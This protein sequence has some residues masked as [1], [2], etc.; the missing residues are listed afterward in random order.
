MPGGRPR[1]IRNGPKKPL[2]AYT[3]FVVEVRNNVSKENPD[4]QFKEVASRVGQM[5]RDLKD[6]HREKYQA[7]AEQDKMRYEREKDEWK[8]RAQQAPPE[9]EKQKRKKR[10]GAPKNPLSA[11]TYY[12]MDVRKDVALNN[13][14]MSFRDVAVHVGQMWRNLD[15]ES[16]SMYSH[17]AELDKARY[18]NEMIDWNARLQAEATEAALESKNKK[19]KKSGPKNPLSAYTYFVME[20]RPMV[21]VENPKMTF[22]EVATRVGQMWRG[23]SPESRTKYD[24]MAQQDKERYDREKESMKQRMAQ[25]S[26]HSQH[27]LG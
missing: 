11:Y 8:V 25:F 7:L 12:I 22:G 5:W 15:A 4:L 24:H 9:D 6:E 27:F 14:H 19:K 20:T 3:L 18:E 2:S 26:H 16:R 23:L 10:K 21:S 1:K 13:P 17:K